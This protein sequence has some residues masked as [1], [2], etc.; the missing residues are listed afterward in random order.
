MQ[1]SL[2]QVQGTRNKAANFKAIKKD[3]SVFLK[4]LCGNMLN[5]FFKNRSFKR[6]ENRESPIFQIYDLGG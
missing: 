1:C 3:T 4:I 5:R 6:Y 2:F